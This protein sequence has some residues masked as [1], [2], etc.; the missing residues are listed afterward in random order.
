MTETYTGNGPLEGIRVVEMGQL[1]AG[2][3]CGQLLGDMGAEIVKLEAPETGD[4]M[5]HWGQ[6]DK[7]S[8]WRVVAR[9]KYSVACN[10]RSA[11]GQQLARDLI[12]KADILIENF[13]PGTLEKWNLDP[14]E[15]R[16]T[17]P[18]LIVVRVSGYGQTGPY[19][20]R[21]GF[22]GI[23]EAMGG[24]RGIV[25]HPDRPPARM[26][27]SIGD[28]LAASYGCM[29]ALAALH[30]RDKTGEGQIVDSALYEAVLQ[31][32]E[33]TISD[34]STSGTK[35]KRT[36]S[37]LPAIAPSNVYPCSDGEYLI[38][39]NQD[40]VFARLAE[41]MG[42]PEL[43]IDERYATHLARGARQEELDA[44]ISEWT[45]MMTIEELEAKM[46]EAGVPAGR[47][48]D[49]EDM[50]ADP[51][52]TARE[53]LV[54]VPDAEFGEVTMQNVFPKMSKT[55]G[56]VRR[57]APLTIGQDSDDV[58][59]RWLGGEEAGE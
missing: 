16:K 7:P 5:R 3:F 14:A 56:S 53:A 48:Y 9:N 28:T 38:G 59:Q 23:G 51:H 34:Y 13:R 26:G 22:G 55:P 32:M 36:G 49:A 29:G 27:V 18:G 6:G 50:M 33:S 44:L 43:A 15:L 46:I 52:F 57:P 54:S 4:P 19:S 42:Q 12:A 40:G 30:H 2:P 37:T 8:W 24:W 58:I 31:V 1:I 11:E 45:Q 39:A 21:A 47:I 41:A 20:A 17:N 35:R 25:G 10:L